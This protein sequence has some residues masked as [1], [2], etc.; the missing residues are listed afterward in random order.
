MHWWK[1]Q[2]QASFS[3]GYQRTEARVS[4]KPFQKIETKSTH[5]QVYEVLKRAILAGFYRPGEQITIRGLA[6]QLGTSEMPVREAI[7][8]LVARQA[9]EATSDRKFR[10]PAL[11]SAQIKDILELR[12]LLEGLAVEQAVENITEKHLEYLEIIH[13]EMDDAISQNDAQGLVEGNIRF[14]FYIYDQCTNQSLPPIIESLWL[15]YAPTLTE[16]V[17]RVMKHMS[18]E[19]QQAARILDQER[20]NRVLNALRAHDPVEAR[21]QIEN[22]LRAFLRVVDKIGDNFQDDFEQHRTVQD[23]AGLLLH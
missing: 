15:Q 20:H 19:D 8:R 4:I 9:I 7:K 22:D 5:V 11:S 3:T 12:L 10:I 18:R 23:Y 2:A 1:W 21:L 14:H 17:P 13:D 16:Y 6:N